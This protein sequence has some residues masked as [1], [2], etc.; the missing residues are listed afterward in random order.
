MQKLK[1]E[2]EN[3]KFEGQEPNIGSL[4]LRPEKEEV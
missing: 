3:E 1:E 2:L 4:G